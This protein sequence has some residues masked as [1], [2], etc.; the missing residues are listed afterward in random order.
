[1][2]WNGWSNGARAVGTGVMDLEL[3]QDTVLT[4]SH[5]DP[6]AGFTAQVNML[7]VSKS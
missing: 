4:R 1:M 6:Q 5:P 7:G 3:D 2:M